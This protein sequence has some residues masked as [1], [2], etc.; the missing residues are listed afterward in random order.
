MTTSRGNSYELVYD[1]DH[2]ISIANVMNNTMFRIPM[3]VVRR[4]VTSDN[5]DYRLKGV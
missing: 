5:H 1:M 2:V 3:R 4:R